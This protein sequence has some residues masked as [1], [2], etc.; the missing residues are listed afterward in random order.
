[1]YGRRYFHFTYTWLVIMSGL[2]LLSCYLDNVDLDF[3]REILALILLGMMSEWFAVPF[4]HGLLSGGFAV[5]FSSFLIYGLETAAWVVGLAVLFGQGIANRGNPVRTI[6]FNSCQYVLTLTGAA[7]LYDLAGGTGK[8]LQFG[9]AVPL[10]AFVLGYLVINH[11]LVYF[12]LLPRRRSSTFVNWRD[13]L[14]WDVA[15]YLFTAPYGMLMYFFYIKAGI[16]GIV[17]SFLPVL[18]AQFILQLYN[19]LSAT[20]RELRALYEVARGLNDSLELDDVLNL[21]LKEARRVIR[22]HSGV[23]YLR[24]EGRGEFVARAAYGRHSGQLKKLK[25]KE[26]GGVFWRAVESKESLL[27]Q[28]TR[29]DPGFP[30]DEPGL[31]YLYRSLIA[32]PLVIE[33]EVLGLLVVG[34]KLPGSFTG[35]HLDFLNIIAGQA[36]IAVA[37]TLLSRRLETSA[38]TDGLTGL[39]NYRHFYFLAQKELERAAS[40]GG[41]FSVIMIDVDRFK[42]INDRYGHLVG[43]RVLV[44]VASVIRRAVR[45]GDIVARCGGEEFSVLLP[46][47]G[48]EEAWRLAEK[49][50]VAVRSHDFEVDGHHRQIRISLGVATYPVDALNLEELLYKAGRALYRAKEGGRDR[51]VSF[52]SLEERK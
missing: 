12:Y 4:S 23:V 50:R 27:V 42:F 2:Y 32:V 52:G 18:V 9:D 17:L 37:N 29:K 36:A 25:L 13:A 8:H 34:D 39:Y 35:K 5:V 1:M 26:D 43:D 7:F 44:E 14:L 47:T 28:D 51:T 45:E 24:P 3:G 19:N 6:L 41:Q 10:V 38:A 20:N 22:Y 16:Y 49:I 40:S 15:T 46:S 11:L 31:H 21:V 30:S 48:R 33:G